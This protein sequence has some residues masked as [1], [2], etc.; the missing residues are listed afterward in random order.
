M[1]GP[2]PP[3]VE[4]TTKDLGV[5][6]IVAVAPLMAALVFFGFYPAPLLD[7]SN[8]M[9]GD[10]MHQMGIQDDQPTVVHTEEAH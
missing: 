7:V 5:R 3:E 4:A 6:E 10:L 9:V 8:P 2:T 1:T